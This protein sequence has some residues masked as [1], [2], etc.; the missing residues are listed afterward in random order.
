MA[1][2]VGSSLY[3]T[4]GS[5]VLSADFRSFDQTEE[6]GLVDASAG[7]DANRTYLATLK[8]GKAT[9]ELV[10][11][12]AGTALWDAVVPG[13]TATLTW[14]PEGTATGKQKHTAP[15][16]VMSRKRTYPYDDVVVL[17]VDLQFNGAV[18]D[19]VY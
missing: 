9:V 8:D 17:T 1:E 5:T 10:S 3:L 19:T 12:T 6:V 18:T 4:F 16:I 11:Q 15:T 13:A 14:A 2:F 7:A